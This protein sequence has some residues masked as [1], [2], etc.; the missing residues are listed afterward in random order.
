MR[1]EIHKKRIPLDGSGLVF[2]CINRYGVSNVFRITI[3]LH[4]PID[5]EKLASAY[6]ETMEHFAPFKVKIKRGFFAYYFLP[7]EN[8][9]P[10][11]IP[12]TTVCRKF[13]F[14]QNNRYLVR[15]LYTQ[16]S[17]SLEFFHS[18]CDANSAAI[19]VKHLT[20][21]YFGQA[22]NGDLPISNDAKVNEDAYLRY[23]NNA[24]AGALD[25][26]KVYRFQG[27]IADDKQLRVVR[28]SY[29]T[30]DLLTVAR[31]NG[32]TLSGYLAAVWA[33]AHY[34]AQKDAKTD[35]SAIR[36]A[37]PANLHKYFATDSLRNFSLDISVTIPHKNEDYTFEQILD[38]AANTLKNN[39]N[40]DYL[41]KR[42]TSVNRLYRNFL[43]RFT[44][45]FVK[46]VVAGVFFSYLSDRT[47]SSVLSNLG[48]IN[49]AP[50][51][52]E[53]VD[54]AEFILGPT[55]SKNPRCALVSHGNNIF[56]AVSSGKK[57]NIIEKTF[58]AFLSDYETSD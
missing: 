48:S 23:A 58:F 2:A 34:C 53:N 45:L 50:D 5:A 4:S 47:I 19:F 44:P 41:Q 32:T 29:K 7:N 18:L 49:F 40:K 52:A 11:P 39:K 6:A 31:K 46:N 43:Y 1:T 35:S 30:E 16:N 54:H 55:L 22:M 24:S 51:I 12:D 10:K 26:P 21:K 37:L 57:E 3:A 28:R 13:V 17:F 38:I 36:I 27:E 8:P 14:N 25:I 33:W 9:V 42:I 20:A 15:C 56:I